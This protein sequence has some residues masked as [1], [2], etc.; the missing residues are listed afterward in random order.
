[1]T[2]TALPAFLL[3][4]ACT[5]AP[6]SRPPA[7]ALDPAQTG[8]LT[9]A[10]HVEVAPGLFVVRDLYESGQVGFVALDPATAAAQRDAVQAG[11]APPPPFP[12]PDTDG[13][14]D[15]EGSPDAPTTC[16]EY[17]SDSYQDMT[18]TGETFGE[19]PSWY[20]TVTAISYH[21]TR[22]GR[23]VRSDYVSTYAYTS[24]SHVPDYIYAYGYVYINGRYV[25]YIHDD[26]R[27]RAS[28][29]TAYGTWRV[30]CIERDAIE[31][32]MQTYHYL[33]DTDVASLSIGSS[34]SATVACCP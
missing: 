22:G 18:R 19:N 31:V 3:L 9:E 13:G 15:D 4:A 23:D 33:Y 29:A 30:S 6:E 5:T 32:E 25:G 10:D 27:G 34:V 7:G 21:D 17:G 2:R 1:M 11:D 12:D 14:I 16:Y 20:G 26:G 24:A 28:Y 8:G